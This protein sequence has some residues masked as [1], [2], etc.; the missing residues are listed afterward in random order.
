MAQLVVSIGASKA[1]TTTLFELMRQHPKVAVTSIKE[2]NF[3]FEEAQFASGYAW[4]LGHY[5]ADAAEREVLFEADP[6]YMCS[7]ASLERIRGCDPAVRIIV[8][9]RN[10][11]ERAFSQWA[12]HV[13]LGRTSE[14][15]A[16]AIAL[17]PERLAG[18]SRAVNRW[19]YVERSRYGKYLDQVLQI[20]PRQQVRCIVFE[21]LMRDQ[22]REFA[23]L[24][25]WL[26]LPSAP[27][28]PAHANPTGR[29]RSVRLA[30]IM[31]DERLRAVRRAIAKPLGRGALK[32]TI[33][34]Y[35]ERYNLVPYDQE[36]RP[37]LEPGLRQAILRDLEPD[38]ALTERLTG[39]D[40]SLWRVPQ[41]AAAT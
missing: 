39:L 33:L 19:G 24:T 5:F 40:L 11:V 29:A 1:G 30:R 2:T 3:F 26:G 12:Y 8:M 4:F 25:T 20:F 14:T 13:Q 27:I 23:A 17:E 35:V 31:Y 7:R 22:S 10:P 21:R 41:T 32:R 37:R 38:I 6:V 34:D 9:L 36:D 16:Q 15:F 28:I 18:E